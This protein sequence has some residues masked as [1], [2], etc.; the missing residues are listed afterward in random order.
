MSTMSTQATRDQH[1]AGLAV[2]RRLPKHMDRVV[3][4]Q[5]QVIVV[6]DPS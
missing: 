2:A 4:R 5:I 6:G 3:R 1:A